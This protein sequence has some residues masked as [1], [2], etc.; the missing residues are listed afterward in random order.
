MIKMV[1]VVLIQKEYLYR[2]L[3]KY[4]NVIFYNTHLENRMRM[5]SFHMRKIIEHD[6][7]Y[8]HVSL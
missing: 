5:I 6:I 2:Y 8:K 7:E 4:R 3:L 1:L